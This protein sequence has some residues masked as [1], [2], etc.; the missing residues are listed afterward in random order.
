MSAPTDGGSSPL[1]RGKRTLL[2][3]HLLRP[4]LIP[5]HAGKTTANQ[6]SYNG[7]EAHPRSRGENPFHRCDPH[8]LTGSSPLTRGKLVVGLTPKERER[9]IPAHAGKTRA[10]A[11]AASAA[12]AHPRSRGENMKHKASSASVTGSSPLTRGKLWRGSNDAAQPRLIPA[13]AGKT[14]SS[15]WNVAGGQAHPRSRGENSLTPWHL[16]KQTGSSPLTRGKRDAAVHVGSDHRLIPAHAG[17]TDSRR[18]TGQMCRAHPRSRGE[19]F[20]AAVRAERGA[21]S[22]PLTR[23]KHRRRCPHATAGGLIPA[24]AGKTWNWPRAGIVF[25]AHPR[26]RGEN[27]TRARRTRPTGGSSPLTRGKRIFAPGLRVRVGLIPAHAGKTI[28]T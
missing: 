25:A 11:A 8:L 15:G 17:K 28:S 1:T 24:H 16:R 13:H 27:Y 2:N 23:G 14:V 7:W 19:N 10:L 3:S 6:Y 21:G 9:L 18:R 26:S 20:L 22:S 4:R 5:A 12:S